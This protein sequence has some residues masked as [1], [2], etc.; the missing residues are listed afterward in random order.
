[1]AVVKVKQVHATVAKAVAYVLNA[2]KTHD[3]A[4]AASNCVLDANDANAVAEQ[5]EWMLSQSQRGSITSGREV[6]SH[7]VIQSFKP[8][9]VTDVEALQIGVEFAERITGGDYFYVVATHTDR[10]H[11]HNH[12]HICPV[13][14]TTHRKLR[15]QRHTLHEW[16]AISDELCR[17]RSLSVVPPQATRNVRPS[18]GELHAQF[19][20]RSWRD[21]VRQLVD[22]AAATSHSWDAFQSQ[23]ERDGMRVT[24]RNGYVTYQLPGQERAVRDWRLGAGYALPEVMARLGREVVHEYS[25]QPSMI[26]RD[27]SGTGHVVALPHTHGELRFRVPDEAVVTG[28]KSVRLFLRDN[29]VVPVFTRNGEFAQM[30]SRDQLELYLSPQ[31][32]RVGQRTERLSPQGKSERHTAFLAYRAREAQRLRDTTAAWSVEFEYGHDRASIVE[33]IH[34]LGER[35]RELVATQQR[36]YDD[37]AEGRIRPD[38]YAEQASALRIELDEVSRELHRLSTAERTA[39]LSQPDQRRAR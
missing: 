27:R 31:T 16:R 32:M 36:L 26:A 39:S 11:V 21:Q 15:M 19:A 37:M 7:H 34:D 12:I 13:H 24:V 8:G 29:E 6:L 38:V 14:T 20:G 17:A 10:D 30:F 5:F 4:L 28:S 35:Q 23:L 33:A 18:L 22:D 25:V 9:E 1:M 2:D 3:G